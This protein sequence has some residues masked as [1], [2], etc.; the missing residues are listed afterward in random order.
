M[1]LSRVRPPAGRYTALLGLAI[2]AISASAP[3]HSQGMPPC[4]DWKQI[5]DHLE[6]EFGEVP[7]GAGLDSS[8]TRMLEVYASPE[9]G[10]TVLVTTAGG[11][12]C[13]VATGQGWKT[14]APK[15]KEP[16]RPS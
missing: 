7:V 2:L 15:A 1:I 16:G 6:K 14:I 8:G 11:P 3:G 4:G 10:F 9:G 12:S 5:T 13:I